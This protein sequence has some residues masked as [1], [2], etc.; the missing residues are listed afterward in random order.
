MQSIARLTTHTAI[1]KCSPHYPYSTQQV[2]TTPSLLFQM[3]KSKISATEALKLP[4]DAGTRTA[5]LSTRRTDDENHDYRNGAAR[6][7]V[8]INLSLNYR[9]NFSKI[10]NF[11]QIFHHILIKSST[12]STY[13]RTYLRNIDILINVILKFTSTYRN[14]TDCNRIACSMIDLNSHQLDCYRPWSK[15]AKF[16]SYS[17]NRAKIVLEV[18]IDAFTAC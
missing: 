10:C 14:C 16:K 15:I 4:H 18:G 1:C 13:L 5:S 17:Q 12:K 7:C 2:P 3:R 6:L 11:D 8:V 9:P